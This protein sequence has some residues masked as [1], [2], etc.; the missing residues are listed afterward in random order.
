MTETTP[1]KKRSGLPPW[2]VLNTNWE[3]SLCL[4]LDESDPRHRPRPSSVPQ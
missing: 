1:T 3:K 2:L 4:R